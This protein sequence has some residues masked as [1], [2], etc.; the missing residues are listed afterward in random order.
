[1]K[2]SSVVGLF[3][4]F[5]LVF[6]TVL[7]SGAMFATPPVK[8]CYEDLDGDTYGSTV[9]IVSADNDCLDAGESDL[10]TDCDDSDATAYPGATEIPGNGID[11]NC[12]GLDIGA[13]IWPTEWLTNG[14]CNQDP[15]DVTP[16]TVDILS[17]DIVDDGYEPAV[18]YAFDSDYI[19]LRERVDDDPAAN[20]VNGNY[21]V[22]QNWVLL[23]EQ[24]EDQYYD[25]LLTLNGVDELVQIWENNPQAEQIDWSPI[26]NDPADTVVWSGSTATYAGTVPDGLGNYFVYWAVP[27]TAGSF[28]LGVD[29]TIYFAT[30]SNAN[31][32]NKDWLDC[33]ESE[34]GNGIVDEGEDCDPGVSDPNDCCSDLCLFE[35]SAY[36]CRDSAGQCDAAETCTGDSALCPEDEMEP[37]ST[38]CDD[39]LYCSETDHCDGYGA[40]V[41]LTARD[42][43]DSNDCT[44]DSCNEQTDQCDNTNYPDGTLCGSVRDCPDSACSG[45]FAVF[46]PVDGHDTCSS[47]TCIQ[48]SCN[49]LFSYCTD[50]DPF[51]GI[52]DL[53]CGAACDEDAD[54]G[55]YCGGNIRYYGGIC[56][57]SVSCA[58]DYSQENCDD[59]DGCTEYGTGCEDRNYFCK[60][61]GCDFS[62]ANSHQDAYG[63]YEDYCFGSMIRN[64]RE[65]NDYYCEGS[66]TSHLSWVDDTFVEDCDDNDGW[67][68]TDATKWIATDQCNEKEQ[69]E[70][71]YRDYTCGIG[72]VDCYYNVTNTQWADTGNTRYVQDGTTC[73]DGLYCTVGDQ[74]TAG[75]CGGSSRDC[76]GLNDQCNVGVCNEDSD[77]CEADSTPY[78]GLT[79]NDGLFCNVGE[80]CQSGVC[81]GG[82]DRDCG[83]SVGCTVDSC[84][85][86]ND[87][88]VSIPDDGLCLSDTICADYFCDISLDCQVNFEPATTVCRASEGECDLAE[89]C[90]GS[91]ADCPGDSKST[92][93]CRSAVDVCDVDDYCDGTNNDCPLDEKA[94]LSTPCD[95][96][97]WCSE[98]DHCDGYG[99]CVQLTARDCSGFDIFQIATCNNNPD[100][101][102][103]TWDFR[104][105]FT[106]VCDEQA[107]ACTTGNDTIVHE[108]HDCDP[109]DGIGPDG[110]LCCAQCDQ[111]EDCTQDT[112]Y[113]NY[114]TKEYCTRDAYGTCDGDCNCIYDQ[115]VCDSQAYCANCNHCG[116]DELNCG[117]E[118]EIGDIGNRCLQEGT[119]LL[120]CLNNDSY[121]FPEFD[122]CDNNCMWN[123]CKEIVTENDPRCQI[124]ITPPSCN[125]CGSPSPFSIPTIPTRTLPTYTIPTYTAPTI[126]T[127]TIP[128]QTTSFTRPT[129]TSTIT[130]FS[131]PTLNFKYR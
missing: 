58:C 4:V 118:C 19:Y 5:S 21:F 125:S 89:T 129:Y 113:C 109:N 92:D 119:T 90:T 128:T 87:Q 18:F 1:M 72:P 42:C 67:Y 48:Y 40:C 120:T 52:N 34:C 11:E 13:P 2:A 54:C 38:P 65:F 130:S 71:E 112:G 50:N 99:A 69:K 98:T 37:L 28:T 105:P 115:W 80:T 36:I 127:Y 15:S 76:S 94:P 23:I 3:L 41:Q 96:G 117:E 66:C 25:Y 123:D 44:E 10:N 116:D 106:S 7:L 104:N 51:D 83:D 75:V 86:T 63:P 29:P 131:L 62:Y 68:D 56:D 43:D 26:F 74:C 60:P 17:V 64:H 110:E 124:S 27:K 33:Y 78:E 30:S 93:L 95:D 14:A 59:Y 53:S 114:D 100:N 22:S 49:M 31:N 122:S 16:D 103:F 12:D 46:Y 55:N 61:D 85:E 111:D 101:N 79:C 6:S 8:Y 47:G 88:C 77:Q 97:L 82:S 126:P 45:Y 73:D 20:G 24:T 91:S 102:Q 108:C 84:D 107:D 121:V 39:G 70:Q 32:Y 81:T 35:E 9:E 57:T